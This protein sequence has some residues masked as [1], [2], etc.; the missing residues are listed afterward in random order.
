MTPYLDALTQA[1]EA[2]VPNHRRVAR[3]Y[4][5]LAAHVALRL[6]RVA[7]RPLVVGIQGPQGCGKS[8]LAGALCRPFANVGVRS[9]SVSV[10]DFYLTRAEQQALAL[11]H[12]GDR[13]MEH[14]GYPGT[15]DVAFGDAVLGRLALLGPGE[16]ALVPV[17]DKSAH[18][19]RGDRAPE[20]AW[21]AVVGPVDVIFFEGWVLGFSQV[22]EV[23]LDPLLAAPNA[24]LPAYDA[25]SRRLDFFIHMHPRSLETIV[26]WRVDAERARRA[27]GEAALTDTKA[28]DYIERFIP[29][30]AVYVPHLRESPP[31]ADMLA[32]VLGPDRE[33]EDAVPLPLPS[34]GDIDG[35]APRG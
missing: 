7:R 34:E 3:Y 14:R 30:Y 24:Y 22:S 13:S 25:W 4:A 17:Y 18:G 35:T 33:P 27:R 2:R 6:S 11:R 15:H 29:G 32:L 28:R 1:L 16:E 5:P 26:E 31:C 19:G 23:G 20:S 9:V 8:T 10:D 21:R 12:P